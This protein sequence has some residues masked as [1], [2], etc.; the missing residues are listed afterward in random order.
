[1][2]LRVEHRLEFVPPRLNSVFSILGMWLF[3]AAAVPVCAQDLPPSASA[4]TQPSSTT[5]APK[6]DA[7][8]QTATQTAP[9]SD[10]KPSDSNIAEVTTHDTPATFKV[11]VNEVL[12]RVVVRDE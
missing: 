12:V 1:M 7:T 11:R 2:L 9:A 4:P 8:P 6:T 10:A 3:L 5:T